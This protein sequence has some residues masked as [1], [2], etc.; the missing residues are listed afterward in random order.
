MLWYIY[1]RIW[2]HGIWAGGGGGGVKRR[3]GGRSLATA[4][5]ARLCGETTL[6][7]H[8]KHLLSTFIHQNY[9]ALMLF[10]RPASQQARARTLSTRERAGVYVSCRWIKR[11][12]CMSSYCAFK[13]GSAFHH[14]KPD[15]RAAGLKKRRKKKKGRQKK[16][17]GIAWRAACSSARNYDA[18]AL[19]LSRRNL[20]RDGRTSLLLL[21]LL[22]IKTARER[23]RLL[24]DSK[25]APKPCFSSLAPG[26]LTPWTHSEKVILRENGMLL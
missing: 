13:G 5:R 3:K 12:I 10:W 1:T 4:A 19:R 7:I 16:E 15:A 22:G 18:R 2:N 21:L 25:S 8:N 20:S 26:R 23:E 9:R 14:S 17:E 6:I 24:R 11:C